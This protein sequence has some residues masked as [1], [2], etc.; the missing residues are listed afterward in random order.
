MNIK[1]SK[2]P[3]EIVLDILNKVEEKRGFAGYY[4]E[5]LSRQETDFDSRDRAFISNMVQGVQRWKLRLDWIISRYSKI[6]MEKIDQPILNI[7]RIA[8]FQIFFMDRVPESAAVNEAVN[9]TKRGYST[10]HAASFVNAVLRKICG[11]KSRVF[12]PDK[13]SDLL[14]NLSVYY[15]FPPWLIEKWFEEVGVS[16]TEELLSVLNEIPSVNVRTNILKTD[17]HTLMDLLNAEGVGVRCAEFSPVG[18]IFE[19]FRGRVDRLDSFKKGLFQV[20]D[21]AAQITSYLLAPEPGEIVLDIG[22]GLGGKSSHMAELMGGKGIVVSLDINFKRLI[23]LYQNI[24]RL[25]IANILPVI[26]D[27]AKNLTSVFRRK[28]DRV[29]IDAPCTGFGVISR[30]PDGKWNRDKHSS[31]RLAGLQKSIVHAAASVLKIN[32]MM[33]YVT[34]TISRDENENVVRDILKENRSLQL[35]NL[36]G[37]IPEWGAEL[38]DDQ[39]FLRILPHIHHMDGFFA[40]LFRKMG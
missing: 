2:R 5:E 1:N 40:A 20:Q 16:S 34:C 18:I 11:Q 24:K 28:F 25:D 37:H 27:A 38:I 12:Y 35:E 7:L 32:G 19:D 9:L 21:E 22:A 17:R 26:A 36:H 10:R 39:G 8:V 15:S 4:L 3:R 13:N 31:K 6:P 23:S 14:N 30:H 33:L 29:M